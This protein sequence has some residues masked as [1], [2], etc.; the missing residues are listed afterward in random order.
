ATGP[1]GPT[2]PVGVSGYQIVRQD[3]NNPAVGDGSTVGANQSAQCPTG[4][5]VLG[6]GGSAF[7]TDSA[8][9]VQDAFITASQPIVS[10]GTGSFNILVQ[11]PNDSVF[12]VGSSVGGIVLA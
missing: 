10:N 1:P 11:R 4:M 5:K 2:G 12:P 7:W 9:A 8:G 3:F 6:G